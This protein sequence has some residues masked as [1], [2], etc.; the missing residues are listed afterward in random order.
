MSRTVCVTSFSDTS[1]RETSLIRWY[2]SNDHATLHETIWVFVFAFELFSLSDY[3]R[4]FKIIIQYNLNP[5]MWAVIKLEEIKISL[6]Y[7]HD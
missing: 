2:V 4:V 6:S 5:F 7:N 3:T 1:S